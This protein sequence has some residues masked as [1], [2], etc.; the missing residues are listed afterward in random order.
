MS[1]R[2]PPKERLAIATLQG[3]ALWKALGFK[4]ARAFQRAVQAGRAGIRLYPVPGQSRG[5]F[6]RAEDVALFH[7]TR[8]SASAISDA[9]DSSP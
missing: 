2:R 4:N 6:A 9:E 8:A 5:W 3:S 7:K 1:Q